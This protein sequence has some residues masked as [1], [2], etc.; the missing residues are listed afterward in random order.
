ME[1]N[2]TGQGKQ[3]ALGAEVAI[4]KIMVGVLL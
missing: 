4:F 2:K 1:K 3:N